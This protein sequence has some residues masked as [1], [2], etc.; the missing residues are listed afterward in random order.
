MPE[1]DLEGLPPEEK[2]KKL[3]ELEEKKKKEIAEAQKML[4]ESERELGDREEWRRK[5]P[6]PQVAAEEISGMSEAE[7][8]IIEAHKGLRERREIVEE[9]GLEEEK[10]EE[11][12]IK[13]EES[14]EETVARERVELPEGLMESEYATK[15]SQEP[16][17]NLYQEMKDIYQAV[18]EKG[19]ISREEERKI[20]YLGAATERKLEDIEAGKYSLTEEAAE[21]ALL[22]KRIGA[23]LRDMYQRGKGG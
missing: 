12:I 22:T 16:M 7:R 19:Y 18:E 6:I 14:L 13:D 1:D 2:I 15:L 8:E 9:E 20:G 5:V 21:A 3:K 4:K 17:E 10:K 11:Q 23:N